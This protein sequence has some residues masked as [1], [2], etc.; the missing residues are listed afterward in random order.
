V[1]P[2]PKQL[3]TIET[4]RKITMLIDA[5]GVLKVVILSA[6]GLSSHSA[7]AAANPFVEVKLGQKKVRSTR[8]VK[9]V[10]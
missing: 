3:D 7:H 2:F 9:K 1:L 10:L 5:G 4:I 8:V 6:E